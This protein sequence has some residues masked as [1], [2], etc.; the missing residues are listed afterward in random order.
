M[1]MRYDKLFARLKDKEL[2]N[3][4]TTYTIR[5]R[6][7]MGQLT[8]QNLRE[9]KTVKTDVICRLCYLLKCKPEDIM[10]YVPDEKDGER[11]A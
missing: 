2:N 1:P 9:G 11:E 4:I 6:N 10:E 3:G 7:I 5:T 8:L